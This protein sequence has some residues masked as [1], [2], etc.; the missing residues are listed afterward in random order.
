MGVQISSPLLLAVAEDCFAL[1]EERD[2]AFI[3][4]CCSNLYDSISSSALFVVVVNC[5][6]R[7]LLFLLFGIGDEA[8][9][10]L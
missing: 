1:D 4:F 3:P 6:L 8:S 5:N 9:T 10:F 7:R 2:V